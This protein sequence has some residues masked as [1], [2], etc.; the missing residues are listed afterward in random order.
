VEGLIFFL[1]ELLKLLFAIAAILVVVM[2]LAPELLV[3]LL[4]LVFRLFFL[5]RGR[6]ERA[7]K[8]LRW[9][10]ILG[11]VC[12]ASFLMSVII[13]C[14]LNTFFYESTLRVVLNRIERKTG[15]AV[16][17]ET[18]QGSFWAGQADMSGVTIVRE[19]HP[20]SNFTLRAESCAVDISMHNLLYEVAVFE[21]MDLKGLRGE[22]ERVGIAYR[23]PKYQFELGERRFGVGFVVRTDGP[24]LPRRK[25]EVN[26]LTVEDADLIVR[27]QAYP[28]KRL[29]ARLEIDRLRTEPLISN[30]PLYSL[31]YQTQVSGRLNGAPFEIG[32][33]P[34][35]N[36]HKT[37]WHAEQVPFEFISTYIGGPMRWIQ[38]A[39]L[40]VNVVSYS[41]KRAPSER[42]EIEMHWSF[43]LHDV[44]AAVP[45]NAGRIERAIAKPVVAFLN[46]HPNLLPITFGYVFEEGRFKGR[47]SLEAVG[48]WEAVEDA[49][50]KEIA[51]RIGVEPQKLK[52]TARQK[53]RKLKEFLEKARSRQ[54]Q[55]SR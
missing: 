9:I 50:V 45:A 5:A 32:P 52:K 27:D 55:S 34:V 26:R 19:N 14:I 40:D 35:D 10:R 8:L 15:I 37:R 22:Y 49:L 4:E 47:A 54:D 29:E 11:L 30:W 1:A 3:L 18:A 13:M 16:E 41:A 46:K 43:V 24:A 42:G 20:I 51:G 44:R 6:T 33:V 21:A 48:L 31:L 2:F 38:Q 36:G 39:R 25:F 17:F 23:P 12:L 28:K 53:L 7:K